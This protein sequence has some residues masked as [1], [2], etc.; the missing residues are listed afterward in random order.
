LILALTISST[1]FVKLVRDSKTYH[2]DEKL[3]ATFTPAQ[4]EFLDF[5]R[6]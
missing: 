2:I 4:K 3:E 1:L 5:E 6:E